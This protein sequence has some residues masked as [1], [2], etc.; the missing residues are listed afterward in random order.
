MLAEMSEHKLSYFMKDPIEV[1]L[2]YMPFISGGGL[3]IPTPN[4]GFSLEDRVLVEVKLPGQD[5]V[6][7]V[8]GKIVWITPPN[9]LHHVISGI[10]IQFIGNDSKSICDQIESHINKKMDIGGY[11]C[12][13]T[14]KNK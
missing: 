12:G 4:K 10:G 7:M 14:D 8:T 11:T 9:A 5:A 1:N 6:V 2:S 13:L 3:F